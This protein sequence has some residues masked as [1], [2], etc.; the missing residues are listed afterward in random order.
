MVVDW[1]AECAW[2]RWQNDHGIRSRSSQPWNGN[3]MDTYA[4]DLSALIETLNLRGAT[5]VGHS[6]GGTGSTVLAVRYV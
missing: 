1:V 5:L 3:D 6:T 2:N 4:D